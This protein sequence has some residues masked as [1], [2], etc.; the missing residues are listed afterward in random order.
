MAGRGGAG[1]A[2]TAPGRGAPGTMAGGAAAGE[3]PAAGADFS[4]SVTSGGSGCRGPDKICPG[5][6]AGGAVRGCRTGPRLTGTLGSGGGIGIVGAAAY[7]KGGVSGCPVAKGGRRGA[8]ARTGTGGGSAGAD[9]FTPGSGTG[10]VPPFCGTG[11]AAVPGAADVSLGPVA[12][13]SFGAKAGAPS[14]P[15]GMSPRVMRW[16]S[17][18]ATSSSSELECVF[19]SATPS[20][21]SMSRMTLGLT[22][23]SRASSLI[24]ILLIHETPKLNFRSRD[25]SARPFL[26]NHPALQHWTLRRRQMNYADDSDFSIVTDSFSAAAASPSA[27]AASAAGGASPAAASTGDVS[28]CP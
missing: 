4:A 17:F 22:S 24:R 19:F 1:I 27:V 10:V 21:G 3:A 15:P 16:R 18:S 28:N 13:C 7:P 23:S 2:G 12:T 5:L 11:S 8:I 26:W 25:L 20:S 14:S 9:S 6:G